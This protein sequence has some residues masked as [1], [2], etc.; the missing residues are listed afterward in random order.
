MLR[1]TQ[2]SG[3]LMV[4]HFNSIQLMSVCLDYV[5]ENLEAHDGVMQADLEFSIHK[6]A[7]VIEGAGL[8]HKLRPRTGKQC[9]HSQRKGRLILGIRT[10]SEDV[11][12]LTVCSYSLVPAP[13]ASANS[14]VVPE[15]IDCCSCSDL[16]QHVV[17]KTATSQTCLLLYEGPAAFSDF[18]ATARPQFV[19]T[20]LFLLSHLH[21][22]LSWK[23]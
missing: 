22:L 13:C 8:E 14:R 3:H 17:T 2:V 19:V 6:P 16:L 23:P 21:R 7:W 4:D 1:K 18:L 15:G 12:G 10:A 9:K 20:I 5:K 11:R